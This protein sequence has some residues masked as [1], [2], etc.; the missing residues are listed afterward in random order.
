MI[1]KKVFD[2]KLRIRE[3]VSLTI[4][5]ENMAVAQEQA[6]ALVS[7]GLGEYEVEEERGVELVSAIEVLPSRSGN[8]KELTALGK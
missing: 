8:Y 5:A 6:H 2:V 7:N 4:N 1:K 3:M